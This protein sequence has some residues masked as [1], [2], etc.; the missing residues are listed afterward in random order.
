[1]TRFTTMMVSAACAATTL[2]AATALAADKPAPVHVS[3]E[4]LD[5]GLGDLPHYRDWSDKT[6]KNV[7]RKQAKQAK[8]VETA[9]AERADVKVSKAE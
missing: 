3:G 7:M 2:F 6:G 9:P 8:K 4:K 1:M 5:S